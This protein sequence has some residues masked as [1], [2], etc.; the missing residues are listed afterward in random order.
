MKALTLMLF[1]VFASASDLA[2][3]AP[4]ANVQTQVQEALALAEGMKMAVADY[5]AKHEAF[6][7]NNEE[8]RLPAATLIQGR[9]VAQS[10][11]DGSKLVFTFGPGSDASIQ[12]KHLTLVGTLNADKTIAWVCQ[13]DDLPAAAACPAD[14]SC[15][16]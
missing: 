11:V 13:S 15:A 12:G 14:C 9:Y 2:A 5:A 1:V 3:A 7:A 10:A 6:P 4:P 16:P 8:A